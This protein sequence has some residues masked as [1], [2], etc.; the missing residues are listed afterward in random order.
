[1]PN[2]Q[3]P[4]SMG[5]VRSATA[6]RVYVLPFGLTFDRAILEPSDLNYD[7]Q[8]DTSANFATPNLI[9][10]TKT[11]PSIVGFQEGDGVGKAFEVLM[12]GRAIDRDVTWY[13]R[14]R[15]NTGAF[16]SAW[17]D[18]RSFVVAQRRDLE[19]AQATYDL[20][21]DGNA[22]SK[23]A[24]SANTYKL[25][26]QVG[27]E[28]DLLLDEKDQSV[29]D[30]ALDTARDTALVNNFS[31]YLGLQRSGQDVAAHHRW[32][33]IKLWKAFINL[34]GTQQGM[35]DSVVAFLAEPPSILDLT[36][37]QG[38][39]I[40]RD[41]I[42]VPNHP[43][44]APIIVVYSRPQ[45]GHSFRLVIFNSWDLTYDQAVLERFLKRQKPAHAQM[46]IAYSTNRHWSL[47]YDRQAD[48]SLWT[49][50]GNVD[51]TTNNTIRLNVGTTSGTLTSPV[52]RITTVT[53]YDA[54][55]I[56]TFAAGQTITVE[57]RT[58]SD[59]SAFSSYVTLNHGV[60]PDSSIPIVQYVQFRITLSRTAAGAPN[61]VLTFFE[62]KG[63]RT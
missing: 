6:D 3:P 59:G 31:A 13:W 25:I 46:T 21:A 55:E 48:W 44:I 27:R 11:S 50:S 37:T 23:E 57:Y 22:Y 53:A 35:V 30:L 10:L 15:I 39:I 20:L 8:I 17:S 2:V 56:T 28:L 58:S 47:R 49:N 12:P 5:A 45:R 26:L 36:S 32:K 7:L 61:P 51:T 42:K 14:V 16:L 9:A 18:T 52:Q 33:T 62:F 4:V 40:D 19:Q 24:N 29:S 60:E 1:M 34:P 63:V 41:F 43:E 54:P 38:W